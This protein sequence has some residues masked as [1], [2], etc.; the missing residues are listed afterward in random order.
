M[1]PLGDWYGEEPQGRLGFV[2]TRSKPVEYAQKTLL[3]SAQAG[4]ALEEIQGKELKAATDATCS[5]ILEAL[6]MHAAADSF[7][8]LMSALTDGQE[9]CKLSARQAIEIS[10]HLITHPRGQPASHLSLMPPF[11]I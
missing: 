3:S 11:T 10:C 1:Q 4:N 6:V 5:R 2:K 8:T 7:S 9:W